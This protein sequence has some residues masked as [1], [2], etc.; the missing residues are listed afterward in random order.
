[1]ARS[2][3]AALARPTLASLFHR[4]YPSELTHTALGLFLLTVFLLLAPKGIAWSCALFRS[5]RRR[6]FAGGLR[7]T[8]GV[9]LETLYSAC[10]APVLMLFHSGFLLSTLLGVRVT[11]KTQSRGERETGLREALAR[12]GLHTLI[13]A[14]W[15]ALA[16]WV[17]PGLFWWLSP[18]WLPLLLSPALSV[19]GSRARLGELTRR[20]GLFATPEETAPQPELAALC[21]REAGAA[22]A[23][24]VARAV[25]D[26]YVNAA[27]ALL[28]RRHTRP[29]RTARL[30]K[31]R[32]RALA[33]GPQG[34]APRELRHLLSDAGSLVALH[35]EVWRLAGRAELP[36]AWRLPLAAYRGE[37]V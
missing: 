3:G 8:A 20:A 18:V 26:P 30:A 27:H 28:G 25:V 7:L 9:L 2:G 11:W 36:D 14:G 15:A 10:L 16:A 31:L 23:D 5:A 6:S 34:L 1:V 32:E 22:G 4:S 21:L 13:A 29:A 35:R 17:A 12:H 33:L 37:G 19:L 24:A